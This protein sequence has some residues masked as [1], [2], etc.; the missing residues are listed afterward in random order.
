MRVGLCD[1][2]AEGA[3]EVGQGEVGRDTQKAIEEIKIAQEYRGR[4]MK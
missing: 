2:L 4:G 3:G 1:P